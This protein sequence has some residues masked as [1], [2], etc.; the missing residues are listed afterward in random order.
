MQYNKKRKCNKA[1]INER[2][3]KLNSQTRIYYIHHTYRGQ[4]VASV[5]HVPTLP[6]ALVFCVLKGENFRG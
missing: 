5:C 4:K 1:A 6:T 2:K 3:Q